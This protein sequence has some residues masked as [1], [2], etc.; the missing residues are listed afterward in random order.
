MNV[1]KQKYD[2]SRISN[3]SQDILTLPV[4]ADKLGLS[5]PI[6]LPFMPVSGDSITEKVFQANRICQRQ[7]VKKQN[8]SML[9][10]KKFY[11]IYNMIYL[12]YIFIGLIHRLSHLVCIWVFK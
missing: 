10:S 5:L 11:G 4:Q 6:K 3:S 1:I 8:Q 2:L 9:L 7:D 12:S